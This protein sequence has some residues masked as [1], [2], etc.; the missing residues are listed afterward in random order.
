M[1]LNEIN[2]PVHIKELQQMDS[3]DKLLI[4]NH[5][6]VNN[7]YNRTLTKFKKET[8]Y[9]L[10]TK[11]DWKTFNNENY[12]VDDIGKD[13]KKHGYAQRYLIKQTEIQRWYWL[14]KKEI[15]I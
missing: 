13:W 6:N 7:I 14:F 2:I 1:N 3:F 15:F 10:N 12:K 8:D 4:W 9:W 5:K 11:I